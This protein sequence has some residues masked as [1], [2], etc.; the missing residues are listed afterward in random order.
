MRGCI[1]ATSMLWGKCDTSKM[2]E[3][4]NRYRELK[5]FSTQDDPCCGQMYDQ[6]QTVRTHDQLETIRRP[7]SAGSQRRRCPD[8]IEVCWICPELREKGR[9]SRQ[10][11]DDR[12]CRRDECP[13]RENV[14]CVKMCDKLELLKPYGDIQAV[15]QG[16]LPIAKSKKCTQLSVNGTRLKKCSAP[17]GTNIIIYQEPDTNIV[18]CKNGNTAPFTQQENGTKLVAAPEKSK[19]TLGIDTSLET[20]AEREK[21][22]S[23]KEL[24]AVKKSAQRVTASR[25]LTPSRHSKIENG[26]RLIYSGSNSAA[27]ELNIASLSGSE[28]ITVPTKWLSGL[29]SQQQSA[30]GTNPNRESVVSATQTSEMTIPSSS[31]RQTE[32]RREVSFN[33]Q[34]SETFT[35]GVPEEYPSVR[36]FKEPSIVRTSYQQVEALPQI[37]EEPSF[38]GSDSRR[39]SHIGPSASRLSGRSFQPSVVY[40]EDQWSQPGNARRTNSGSGVMVTKGPGSSVTIA[41]GYI[42]SQPGTYRTPSS[43]SGLV[44]P[45]YISTNESDVVRTSA[46]DVEGMPLVY[47]EPQLLCRSCK[48][49]VGYEQSM[50]N[51]QQ[52]SLNDAQTMGTASRGSSSMRQSSIYEPSVLQMNAQALEGSRRGFQDPTGRMSS[53]TFRR[54]ESQ[55]LNA[56]DITEVSQAPSLVSYLPQTSAVNQPSRIRSIL[57]HPSASRTISPSVT[58]SRMTTIYED[59]SQSNSQQFSRSNVNSS[60][61]SWPGNTRISQPSNLNVYNSGST[62]MGQPSQT[63]GRNNV[64]SSTASWP[65]KTWISQPSNLNVYNSGSTLMGQPS[66]TSGR[67]SQAMAS[68]TTQQPSGISVRPSRTI[69][70]S[71]QG[72]TR[73]SGIFVKSPSVESAAF[74]E[75]I[76]MHQQSSAFIEEL[77]D[78]DQSTLFVEEPGGSY[79]EI[80]AED[81]EPISATNVYQP[82]TSVTTLLVLWFHSSNVPLGGTSSELIKIYKLR[83]KALSELD[84]LEESKLL[85]YS[86]KSIVNI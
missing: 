26:S 54:P 5:I 57:V 27:S 84:F 55:V 81:D 11:T 74:V 79:L 69:R 18:I 8:E 63:S 66:Q 7:L 72:S 33:Q 53:V 4:I 12:R 49:P 43:S 41:T 67:L 50:G 56:S 16:N 61:A 46:H 65:G 22:A 60:T 14:Q 58:S 71:C 9:K 47:E 30:Y 40:G 59:G 42:G 35:Y 21:Q 38:Q 34:P 17:P 83:A 20:P 39:S 28:N 68:R 45:S 1:S 13:E 32:P 73:P 62:L 25:P 77:P 2:P 75:E 29:I 15:L 10:C 82:P 19:A 76:P 23:V 37:Y 85:K 31:T 48:G 70:S 3:V 86:T 52:V 78:H 80:I 36:S 24:V 44:A 6:C 64:N 51:L